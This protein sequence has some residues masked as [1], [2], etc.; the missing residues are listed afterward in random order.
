MEAS[1]LLRSLFLGAAALGLG[2]FVMSLAAPGFFVG[3]VKDDFVGAYENAGLDV[4]DC[5]KRRRTLFDPSG[6]MPDCLQGT[7]RDL[8]NKMN[9]ASDED[10][11]PR[12]R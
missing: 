6:G 3:L 1:M 2:L 12:R 11:D 10:F 9:D 8:A 4:S 5:K 7:F